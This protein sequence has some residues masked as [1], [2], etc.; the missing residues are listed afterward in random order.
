M[1]CT[2]VPV[3]SENLL[4]LD[5]SLTPAAWNEIIADNVSIMAADNELAIFSFATGA[6]IASASIDSTLPAKLK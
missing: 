5:F 1:S 6:M 4:R 2:V 3:G